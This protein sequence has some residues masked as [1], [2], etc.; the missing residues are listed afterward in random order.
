M[1]YFWFQLTEEMILFSW[2][3]KRANSLKMFWLVIESNDDI[4]CGEN[5]EAWKCARRKIES[6]CSLNMQLMF[7]NKWYGFSL[8]NES[9]RVERPNALINLIRVL[10]IIDGLRGSLMRARIIL[11]LAQYQISNLFGTLRQAWVI[12]V[13]LLCLTTKACYPLIEFCLKHG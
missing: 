10:F 4:N 9:R 8:I 3:E 5:Y 11:S 1:K 7:K 13:L 6:I 12:Y 2:N